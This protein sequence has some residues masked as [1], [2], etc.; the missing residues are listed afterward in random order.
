MKKKILAIV[1]VCFLLTSILIACG[2][3]GDNPNDNMS[4]DN[5]E[6]VN[7][8]NNQNNSTDNETDDSDS[9][10]TLDKKTPKPI[11]IERETIVLVGIDWPQF[12]EESEDPF[13]L[14]F[15]KENYGGNIEQIVTG[16]AE[17]FTKTAALIMAGESPDLVNSGTMFPQIVIQDIIQPI[18]HVMDMSEPALNHLEGVWDLY[19]FGGEHYLLPWLISHMDD[20]FYNT[21]M[22]EEAALD[23]PKELYQNGE[24]NWDTFREAALE[25]KNVFL[26]IQIIN[27]QILQVHLNFL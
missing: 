5:N 10:V 22:F 7:N 26:I 11:E 6:S 19:K 15:F 9:T 27:T 1:V 13:I 23:T 16:N 25:L 14:E 3:T 4:N 8:L 21:Q 17:F 24:W 20:V 2:Q 18:D 12:N